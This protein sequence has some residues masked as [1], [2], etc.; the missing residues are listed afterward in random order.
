MELHEKSYTNSARRRAYHVR[1]LLWKAACYLDWAPR[2]VGAVAALSNCQALKNTYVL[3][4]PLKLMT[5]NMSH[6]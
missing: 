2:A 3:L 5:Y 1:R 4:K 6:K